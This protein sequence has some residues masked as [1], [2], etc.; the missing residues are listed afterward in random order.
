MV[1]V[2]TFGRLSLPHRVYVLPHAQM[3]RCMFDTQITHIHGRKEKSTF[4]SLEVG[5]EYYTPH[6]RKC[7]PEYLNMVVAKC[8]CLI[9]TPE[10]FP[11]IWSHRH[12][13]SNKFISIWVHGVYSRACM[14]NS[15]ELYANRRFIS[16]I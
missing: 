6:K 13:C 1:D 2:A 4:K 9:F 12:S 3:G 15:Q 14:H 10:Y 7:P 8:F 5:V 11:S 16:R